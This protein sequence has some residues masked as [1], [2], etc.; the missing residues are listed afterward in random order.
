MSNMSSHNTK[1][2]SVYPHSKGK[3]R[4]FWYDYNGK[5]KSHVLTCTEKQAHGWVTAKKVEVSKIKSGLSKIPGKIS[6]PVRLKD[7][8]EEF[9][10]KYKLQVKSG[11]ITEKAYKRYVSSYYALK[12]FDDKLPG[13]L[14][15]DINA[16]HF[17]KFKSYRLENNYKPEGINTVIRNLKTLFKFA[18]EKSFIDKSPLHDVKKVKSAKKDVRYLTDSELKKLNV[19]LVSIDETNERERNARDL[20]QFYLL[21]GARASEILAD[22]L[23]WEKITDETIS[24]PISKTDSVRT[25]PISDGIRRVLNRRDKSDKGPF[26]LSHDRV[27]SC[28]KMMY[29]RAGI[30]KAAVHTLR[31]TAGALHYMANRD[32]F[33]ASRFLGHSSVV[34]TESHY[35]GLIQSLQKEHSEKHDQ[36]VSGRIDI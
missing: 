26:N 19:E 35:V 6:G 23:T 9:S 30:E 16:D 31:K 2:P 7:L 12:V 21:T 15:V 27:Y 20:I 33:A 34:I 18:V 24:L 14:L 32:I 22:S 3:W 36:M 25:I 5:K 28:I 11:T 1:Y 13:L 4:V 8:W 17:E 29:K 10:D